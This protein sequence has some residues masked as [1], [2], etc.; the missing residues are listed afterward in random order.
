MLAAK[1]GTEQYGYVGVWA[2]APELCTTVDKGGI[3]YAVIT[4]VSV[5]RGTELTVVDAVTPTEGKATLKAGD[6]AF[7]IVQ[8]SPNA[9]SLNGQALVRCTLP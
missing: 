3:S 1:T 9:I 6:K 5:R 2:A 8:T 4:K 7:D